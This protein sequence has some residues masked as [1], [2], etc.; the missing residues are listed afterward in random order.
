[1]ALENTTKKTIQMSFMTENGKTY[2]MEFNNPKATL[3]TTDVQTVMQMIIDRN[4]ILTT[5][6]ALVSI[7]DGGVVDRTYTDLIP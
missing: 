7:K 2:R 5:N 3:T 1:M 6:G 4:I